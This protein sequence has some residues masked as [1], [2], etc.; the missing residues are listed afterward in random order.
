MRALSRKV[1]PAAALLLVALLGMRAAPALA[2]SQV[3]SREG[4]A[5]QNQI[6]EL[7]R[8]VQALRDQIGRGGAGASVLGGTRPPAPSGSAN[9]M[10]PQLLERV[11]ALEDQ[12]RALRGRSDEVANQ[13][14]RQN[15]DLTKQIGDLN[16]RL[17]SIEGTAGGGGR[18]APAP[19]PTSP[20]PGNLG[21]M[22]APAPAAAAPVAPPGAP[23]GAAP[24]RTP[25]L[26][27]QEGNAA[28]ARRDYAG[29]EAAAREVLAGGKAAPRAYDA[30]F[31]LAQSLA[32]RRDWSQAAIAYDDT[33][34][35]ARTGTH[36]A[37]A[38][39]GLANALTS[40]NEKKAACD[41]LTKL[42]SE[43]PTPRPDLRDQVLAARSRAGC[44]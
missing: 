1:P 11:T 32:G 16:F 18:P 19:S 39:L 12:M 13:L 24:R 25:E 29:A 36:A 6:L 20:P 28:L 37:D 34:S 43:F 22:A 9:D 41:T 44:S 30:Q 15:D 3:D 35:R 5:L 21:A 33:Y 31:L 26:A 42:R 40:I 38:L 14:Q 8:D 10:V 27:M 17:Q 7:R 4:I 2:Q 23:Q